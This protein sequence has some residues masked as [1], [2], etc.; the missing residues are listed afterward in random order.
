MDSAKAIG[1]LVYHGKKDITEFIGAN[2]LPLEGIPPLICIPTT[3]GTGSEVT[4]VSVITNTSITRKTAILNPIL[5]P[6]IAIVDPLLTITMPPQL[7]ASTGMDAL[8]HAIEGYTA[9]SRRNPLSDALAL[10]AIKLISE[11]LRRAVFDGANVRTR[12]NM[13]LASL[14]AGIAF[15]N[16]GVHLGHAFGHMLGAKYHISHGVGCALL[17]P[18]ILSII[19]PARIE[20]LANM[21]SSFGILTT[22]MSKRAA[23]ERTIHEVTQL[24]NDVGLPSLAEVINTTPEDIDVLADLLLEEKRLISYSPRP[25]T[26]QDTVQMFQKAFERTQGN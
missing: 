5:Y 2:A 14:M 8:S 1:V 26:R 20:R 4:K 12:L 22:H 7:T 18:E 3:S 13:S 17:L 21:A 23:A 10:D 15:D 9:T 24:M 19:L 6:K 25:L 11:N 16:T